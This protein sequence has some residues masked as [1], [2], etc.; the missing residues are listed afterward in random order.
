MGKVWD[1]KGKRYSDE[2]NIRVK[3]RQG[4]GRRH[5]LKDCCMLKSQGS[6]VEEAASVPDGDQHQKGGLEL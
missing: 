5:L 2:G 3:Q 6:V 4:G 1:G